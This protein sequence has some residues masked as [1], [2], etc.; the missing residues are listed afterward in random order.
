[1]SAVRAGTTVGLREEQT[2]RA[3]MVEGSGTLLI[4]DRLVGMANPRLTAAT[5]TDGDSRSVDLMVQ[6]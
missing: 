6:S 4:H 3:V 2:G 1:M 5:A